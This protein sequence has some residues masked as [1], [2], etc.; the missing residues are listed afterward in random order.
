MLKI[1]ILSHL[2]KIRNITNFVVDLAVNISIT[3]VIT[4]LIIAM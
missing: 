2:F 1:K 4:A 3:V